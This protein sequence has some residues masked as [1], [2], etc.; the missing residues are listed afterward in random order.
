MALDRS[1]SCDGSAHRTYLQFG[2][3]GQVDLLLYDGIKEALQI[4]PLGSES[5]HQRRPVFDR[6]HVQMFSVVCDVVP[7]MRER[8]WNDVQDF[9]AASEEGKVII[10]NVATIEPPVPL[11][12][13]GQEVGLSARSLVVALRYAERMIR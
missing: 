7:H 12:G 5:S 6:V 9:D 2:L 11:G 8:R 1:S 4:H 13:V 10:F 3:L